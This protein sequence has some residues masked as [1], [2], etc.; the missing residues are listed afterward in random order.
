MG[1]RSAFCKSVPR[2]IGGTGSRTFRNAGPDRAVVVTQWLGGSL[3]R[4]LPFLARKVSNIGEIAGY[5]A[6]VD[7]HFPASLAFKASRESVWSEMINRLSLQPLRGIELGVAWGYASQWWLSRLPSPQLRWDGFDRFSGLP[8]GWRGMPKGAFD[9][10]GMVPVIGDSRVTWHV[11]DVEKTLQDVNL[12][13]RPGERWIVLFDL[14]IFEP[15][16]AAWQLLVAHLRPGDM[17]YFDEAFDRDERHVLDHWIL[18]AAE[19]DLIAYTPLA[20]ALQL[21]EIDA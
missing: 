1:M 16:L 13:R 15:T 18:P 12:E 7:H 9:A 4:A 2:N 8:R 17:L 6:W 11:G 10:N 19:F 3:F 5:I 21:K 14:D 20:L